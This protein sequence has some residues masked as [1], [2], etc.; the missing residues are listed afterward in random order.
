MRHISSLMGKGV[1]M[2]LYTKKSTLLNVVIIPNTACQSESKWVAMLYLRRKKKGVS[3]TLCCNCVCSSLWRLAAALLFSSGTFVFAWARFSACKKTPTTTTQQILSWKT[4]F[5]K[6]HRRPTLA[7]RLW[8][9]SSWV[10]IW[11]R[12]RRRIEEPQ[13]WG[14]PPRNLRN[15]KQPKHWKIMTPMLFVFK[16]AIG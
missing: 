4:W 12:C 5:F 2:T 13:K 6:T 8:C 11:P 10:W 7:P 14:G 15:K 3:L 1:A 9:S 16:Q